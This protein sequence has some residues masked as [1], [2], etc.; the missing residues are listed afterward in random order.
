MKFGVFVPQGWRLGDLPH[1]ISPHEQW[2]IIEKVAFKAEELGYHHIWVYDHFHTVP[3]PIAGKSVF[4]AWTL[5]AALAP[6]TRK[7]RLGQLV[8]CNLYRNPAY[9][10]K[11]S[12][13]V[14]VISNGRLELG[15]GAC[16]YEH[17]FKGYGYRFPRPRVRIEM[18]E[19]AVQIIKKMWTEPEV[20]FEGKYY[21]L[22]AALNDPK[23]VQKP[24]P[25]ILIGGGGEKYTLR[26]VAKHA[27]KWNLGGNLENYAR[28]LEILKKHCKA[29]GRS[30]DDIV[31]T[32]TSTSI[33]SRNEEELRE[34]FR[35]YEMFKLRQASFDEWRKRSLIGTPEEIAEKIEQAKKLGVKEIM[36]FFP[37]ARELTELE[38]FRDEVVKQFK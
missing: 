9:L 23:P 20:H 25:P 11:I 17:E 36:V 13:I 31:L 35:N 8:T 30:F 1:N 7:I 38:I 2:K 26:V 37:Y 22:E 19:E 21:K 34:K 18:L 27:D 14:D 29:V 24:H 4:E 12:S 3:Q 15:I 6:I 16:W 32:W 28:K 5:M 10:A 33:I